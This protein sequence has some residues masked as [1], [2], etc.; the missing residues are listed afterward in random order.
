MLTKRELILGG[1]A[2]A[3]SGPAR[4]AATL[5]E[6]GIYHLDWYVES[7]LDLTDDLAAA[8][9]KGK[10]FAV[11]WGLKGCPYCKRMHEVHMA[12]PKIEGYVR[13]NFDILHLNIIGDREVADFDGRKLGEKGFAA[14]YAVRFTPTVQFFP[15]AAAGL[16]ARPPAERE[17]ARMHGLLDPPDFLAMFRFVRAKG[18][19]SQTFSEWLKKARGI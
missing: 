11:L 8:M 14:K 17:V 7:F 6:D 13:E 9:Q 2:L 1:T 10:R 16:G 19:E 15:E 12:D 5:G 18:Y 3:M 4:S